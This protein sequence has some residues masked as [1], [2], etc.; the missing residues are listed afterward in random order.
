[1]FNRWIS[2]CRIVA[3][4]VMRDNLALRRKLAGELL[5]TIRNIERQ[6]FSEEAFEEGSHTISSEPYFHE[7]SY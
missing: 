6:T 1:M 7:T 4:K 3:K 2:A 5:K